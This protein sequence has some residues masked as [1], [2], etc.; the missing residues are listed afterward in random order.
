MNFIKQ[1][2][3][4]LYLIKP[5]TFKDKRGSFRRAFCKKIYKFNK[6]SFNCVQTNISENLKKGTLRG[7][8]FHKSLKKENKIIT[9][10]SGKM[11]LCV[12]DLRRNSK[13]FLVKKNFILSNRNMHSVIIPAGCA[14]AFLTL[15]NNTTIYYLMDEY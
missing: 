12:V 11:F 1:K 4:N 9:C 2:I 5:E 3:Q 10:L 13:T 8:H 7:F 14:N 15:E 6:I